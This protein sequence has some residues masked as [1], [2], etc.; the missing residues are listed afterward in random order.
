MLPSLHHPRIEHK[1]S[2][3]VSLSNAAEVGGGVGWLCVE[4][5]LDGLLVGLFVGAGDTPSGQLPKNS[6]TESYFGGSGNVGTNVGGLLGAIGCIVGA[7]VVGGS[8]RPMY[9]QMSSMLMPSAFVVASIGVGAGDGA[10]VRSQRCKKV[11]KAFV[12][13]SGA[14][15]GTGTDVREEVVGLG[16]GASETQKFKNEHQSSDDGG[17]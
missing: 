6:H 2:T 15:A 17:I 8:Q 10:A 4:G 11:H 13:D 9:T 1:K 7:G 5:A 12:A 16:T 14:G 3:A